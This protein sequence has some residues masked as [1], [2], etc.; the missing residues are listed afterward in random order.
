MSDDHSRPPLVP[1]S[2]AVLAARSNLTS[3]PD[4]NPAHGSPSDRPTTPTYTLGDPPALSGTS[5]TASAVF[6]GPVSRLTIDLDDLRGTT[7]LINQI[8]E[9]RPHRADRHFSGDPDSDFG[10]YMEHNRN[11]FLDRNV[12]FGIPHPR[13]WRSFITTRPLPAHCRNRDPPRFFEPG[14][15]VEV[16]YT[17]P[18]DPTYFPHGAPRELV[19]DTTLADPE[20]GLP[21]VSHMPP[22]VTALWDDRSPRRAGGNTPYM[23]ATFRG[24]VDALGT[25]VGSLWLILEHI[26]RR[27]S[28]AA[29]RFFA[30]F[31]DELVAED[32][33]RRPDM[34]GWS[35]TTA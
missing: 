27:T 1:L 5:R 3:A 13:N 28:W 14:G 20:R 25:R 15:R 4:P 22:G 24:L 23:H 21:E 33:I 35:A 32:G 19:F 26:R 29:F 12:L 16:H 11:R 30:L 9:F 34:H 10:D 8:P 31:R 6:N 2:A 17:P 18:P 7:A